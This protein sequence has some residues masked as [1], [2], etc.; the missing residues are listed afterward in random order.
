MVQHTTHPSPEVR[1][2][3]QV[4]RYRID[5][6]RSQVQFTTR[7][8]FGLGAVRG[9]FTLRSGEIG[10]ADQVD[11]S[12]AVATI[13][14]GSFHTGTPARDAAVLSESYLAAAR[15]P[16]IAFRSTGFSAAAD[17]QIL[18]GRLEVRGVNAPVSVAVSSLDISAEQLRAVGTVEIDRYAFGVTAGRGLAGR[19]LRLTV[20]VYA[21][22]G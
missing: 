15:F 12:W 13:S 6:V 7:H 20:T 18:A 10:V 4:R 16:D 14:A 17:R 22:A 8:L 2:A 19:R 21:V 1:S 3:S 11:G 9:S 5:P